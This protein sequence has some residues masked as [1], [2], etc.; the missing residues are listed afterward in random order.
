MQWVLPAFFV[1]FFVGQLLIVQNQPTKGVRLFLLDS[2]CLCLETGNKSVSFPFSPRAAALLR[3]R[4]GYLGE[5][6]GFSLLCKLADRQVG[7][8][9]QLLAC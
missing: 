1:V 8:R 5:G 9:S 4:L 6:V 3:L 2:F 7:I